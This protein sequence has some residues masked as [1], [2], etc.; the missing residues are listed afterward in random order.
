MGI[1][2]VFKKS[3]VLYFPGCITY[4]KFKDNFEIYKRIF[5]KLGIEFRIIDKK[6]CCGIPALEAGYEIEA[7]KLAKRNHEI[8]KEEEITSIITNSPCCY[9][10]FLQNYPQMLPDW[11][12]E[13]KNLWRIILTKLQGKPNLIKRKNEGFEAVAYQDS[14]Y[15]GRYCEIYDEPREILKLLG[16]SLKEIPDSKS[17]AI[18]CGSCGGLPITNP[19]LADD[20]AKERIMQAKR[21]GI[22]KIIVAS[23]LDYE[24][25][26]KNSDDTNIEILELGEVIAEALGIIKRKYEETN[27]EFS[28]N[29]ETELAIQESEE[30]K[31]LADAKN[32]IEIQEE[33]NEEDYYDKQRE[34]EN[35]R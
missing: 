19:Q 3:T 24:L 14:C 1:F 16:Y 7:R 22:K 15:L 26:K 12:I 35:E 9:K 30:E 5:D 23:L 28:V 20:I 17:E 4:F 13:S 25:L 2:S 27:I 6:I 31:I 21:I 29:K 18:C 8:F 34:D 33:L 10:M 32:N 11:N